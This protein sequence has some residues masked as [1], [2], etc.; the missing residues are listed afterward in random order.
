MSLKTETEWEKCFSKTRKLDYWY[1]SRT[2]QSSWNKP[3][4]SKTYEKYYYCDP[5]TKKSIWMN[6]KEPNSGITE[7]KIKKNENE[8]KSTGEIQNDFKKMKKIATEDKITTKT[9]HA[10]YNGAGNYHEYDAPD[11][12]DK[13]DHMEYLRDLRDSMK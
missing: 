8:E 9:T 4:Y 3:Y 13:Y 1:N 12:W 2:N 6:S 11:N 5:K 10:V 7:K